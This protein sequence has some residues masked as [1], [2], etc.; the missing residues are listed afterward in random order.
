MQMILTMLKRLNKTLL[1]THSLPIKT[2]SNSSLTWSQSPTGQLIHNLKKVALESRW[3]WRAL[4]LALQLS[5][6]QPHWA[7]SLMKWPLN[8]KEWGCRWLAIRWINS[9]IS[10]LSNNSSSSISSS[11]K[12]NSPLPLP[13]NSPL[14]YKK[15]ASTK[16]S[17]KEKSKTTNLLQLN[18]SSSNSRFSPHT[19]INSNTIM[20]S[21]SNMTNRSSKSNKSIMTK[22]ALNTISTKMALH[23]TLNKPTMIIYNRITTKVETDNTMTRTKISSNSSS[24]M[25]SRLQIKTTIINIERCA[26]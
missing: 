12:S 19:M 18:S 2:T 5:L 25:I 23:N 4:W 22:T 26:W 9:R 6:V 17:W 10:S 16:N 1:R 21:S 3:K 14:S 7:T 8:I 20:G 11:S 13:L 24:T 15:K